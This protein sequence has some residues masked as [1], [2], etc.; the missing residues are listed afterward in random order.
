MSDEWQRTM[1][2]EWQ[3]AIEEQEKKQREAEE[4]FWGQV[5][6]CF[7]VSAMFWLY[8]TQGDLLVYGDSWLVNIWKAGIRIF[9]TALL[10]F[11]AMRLG[12]YLYGVIRKDLDG[13]KTWEK[14][15]RVIAMIFCVIVFV[16][17]VGGFFQL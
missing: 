14:I 8:V 6:G 16:F 12:C 15:F 7:F 11:G 3:R 10:A 9:L 13:N 4:A 5:Y 17:V 2:E 1:N